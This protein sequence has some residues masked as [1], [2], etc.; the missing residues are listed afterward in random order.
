[1]LT[2]VSSDTHTS[3]LSSGAFDEIVLPYAE[4]FDLSTVGNLTYCQ[5]LYDFA[6]ECK[7]INIIE[8]GFGW[9]F[10][11][12]SFIA[13]M[14]ERG[15]KLTSIDPMCFGIKNDKNMA[16]V[17]KEAKNNNIEYEF[18]KSFSRFYRPKPPYCL[19]YIDSDPYEVAVDFFHLVHTVREGGLIVI[20]GYGRQPPIKQA[21]DQVIT[22]EA[23]T[24]FGYEPHRCTQKWYS[25]EIAHAVFQV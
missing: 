9:G 13:A 6:K 18:V 14:S 2:S 24:R 12:I 7:A 20:D 25:K 22:Y 15:G 16:W 4:E 8:C 3:Q 21:I 10:S 19:A 5:N 23:F 1:M 11:A 17:Q